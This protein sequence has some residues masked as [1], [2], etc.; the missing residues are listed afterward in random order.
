MPVAIGAD[1]VGAGFG[2]AKGCDSGGAEET[3]GFLGV[4][5][6]ERA[7]RIGASGGRNA[8]DGVLGAELGGTADDSDGEIGIGVVAC[9]GQCGGDG[10]LAHSGQGGVEHVRRGDAGEAEAVHDHGTA[11]AGGGDD[12]DAAFGCEW[13]AA[14]D[15][16]GREFEQGFDVIDADDAVGTEE[17]VGGGVRAGH[18]AGMGGGQGGAG[19]GTAELV[20][21]DRF[22]LFVRAGGGLGQQIR[23]ADG[24]K[25]KQDSVGLGIVGEHQCDFAGGEVGLVAHAD[26]LGEAEAA[27]GGTGKQ[28]AHDA[29]G[30]RD[31]GPV[32]GD[33][34]RGFERGVDGAGDAGGDVDDRHGVGSEESEAGVVCGFG[35][36]GLALGAVGA[37]FGEAIGE[38]GG[39]G[40]VA[41]GTVADGLFDVRGAGEDVGEVDRARDVAQ[42]RV[43][44]SRP[45]RCPRAG[46]PGRAPR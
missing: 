18:G 14:A 35:Q 45:G 26:E 40:D 31:K 44:L 3:Q 32:A 2:V 38:D 28:R 11:A 37:G 20:G 10:V 17:G 39:D 19:L 34:F 12:A 24:F 25:K 13:R 30:L 22:A 42:G 9:L 4:G 46:S 6:D 5:D 1:G 16:Q 43:R 41:V 29:A 8:G 33:E 7:D 15:H 27:D 23:A 36:A 21:D